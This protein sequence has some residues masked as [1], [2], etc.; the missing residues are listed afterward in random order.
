MEDE[1]LEIVLVS[2]FHTALLL[3]STADRQ[4]SNHSAPH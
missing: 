1:L 3:I 4:H 2:S